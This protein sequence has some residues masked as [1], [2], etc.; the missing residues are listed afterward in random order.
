LAFAAIGIGA[1]VITWQIKRR[2]LHDA[3]SWRHV[4]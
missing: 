3:K 4:A 1:V 2:R